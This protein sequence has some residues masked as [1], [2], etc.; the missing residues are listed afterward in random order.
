M[1]I[2]PTLFPKC[3]PCNCRANGISHIKLTLK[4]EATVWTTLKSTIKLITTTTTT[5]TR[6]MTIKTKQKKSNLSIF[7]VYLSPFCSTEVNQMSGERKE[8]RGKTISTLPFSCL[9][10]LIMRMRLHCLPCV[11]CHLY[12]TFTLPYLN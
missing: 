3:S 5:L 10:D 12:L 11:P 8:E 1:S 2:R 6:P 7:I 9:F 4:L